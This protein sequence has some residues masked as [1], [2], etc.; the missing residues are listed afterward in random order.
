M[1]EIAELLDALN[2]TSDL[3]VKTTV[4]LVLDCL[5]L[6]SC[7][8]LLL[9]LL[10]ATLKLV[11]SVQRL[12]ELV[13]LQLDLMGISFDHNLLDLILLDVLVNSILFGGLERWEFVETVSSS[14]HI[15][16]I[17]R[18]TKSLT[19]L[20]VIDLKD[21]SGFLLLEILLGLFDLTSKNHQAFLLV[22]EFLSEAI[23]FTLK[24][25]GL[26]LIHSGLAHA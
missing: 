24:A 8:N 11:E 26:T 9:E 22:L 15:V 16:T 10:V 14:C 13:L 3:F 1:G 23:S 5:L 21:V 18:D 12:I 7:I 2:D 6:T 20:R 17:K 4:D 19:H 25:L